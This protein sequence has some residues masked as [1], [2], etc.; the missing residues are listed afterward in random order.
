MRPRTFNREGRLSPG[1][2]VR[3]AALA[4]L[5]ALAACAGPPA[6][7][8]TFHRLDVRSSAPRLARPSLP[9]VLEIERV[10][11]EGVLAE[12]AIAYQ[13][14]DG[15]LQRYLYEFWSETPSLMLQ[16]VLARS[17]RAA[18][19]ADTVVTPDLRVPPDWTLRARLRR[20]EHQPAA[21]KVMMSLEVAV[22]SAR[23]GAL[24]LQR[25]Y[26]GEAAVE[27]GLP[28]IS[29]AMDRAVA[30]VIDRL[31]GDVGGLSVPVAPRP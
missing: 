20:F 8:E 29:P 16:D 7:R 13:S 17:L 23:T 27:G 3:L 9:G 10:E 18:G 28:G 26:D 14:G 4:A 5:L 15:A 2:H 19:D 24:L 30:T 22:V 6:P 31:A 21:G 25:D 12:R 11:T 1:S